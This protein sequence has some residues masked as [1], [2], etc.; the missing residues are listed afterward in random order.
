MICMTCGKPLELFFWTGQGRADVC[1]CPIPLV[2][3]YASYTSEEDAT[4][5][6][7]LV[8]G[9]G[10]IPGLFTDEEEYRECQAGSG[11]VVPQVFYAAFADDEL[12][13]RKKGK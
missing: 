12:D 2:D 3:L 10:E 4:Y 7:T 5:T 11:G 13:P 6:V 1:R 8:P 9:G